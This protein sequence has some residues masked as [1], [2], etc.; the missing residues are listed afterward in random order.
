MNKLPKSE[1]LFIDL[2]EEIDDLKGQRDYW[3][4]M[5]EEERQLNI[6]TTNERLK[7]SQKGIAQALALAFSVV[8]NP[9]G[10]LSI[11]KENRKELSEQFKD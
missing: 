11:S 10:S 5:Y 6:D 2:C 1:S 3:R 9:D 7:E 4:K 8:D